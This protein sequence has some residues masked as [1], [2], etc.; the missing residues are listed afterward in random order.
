MKLSRRTRA[1]AAV[2]GAA[3]IAIIAAG[4]SPAS[5]SGSE[6]RPDRTDRRDVQRLRLHRRAPPGV[7][8]REPERHRSSTTRPRRRTTPARTTSRSSARKGLAD[9]E[10]VEVDW[11][12]EVMQ[13]SDLLA[14]VPD[15]RRGPLAR[16]EGSRSHRR[17]RPPHRLRHRHRPRRRIC[18][19]ADLF[20]AAGLPTDRDE[21]AALF[22]G[23]WDNYFDV[24]ATSTRPPPASRCSTPPARV[25]Q[26]MINQ[27]E[28]AYEEPDGTD[29][30]DRQPRGRGRYNASLERAR[31]ATSALPRPV[32]RRLERRRWP[33]AR[34]RPCSARAGCSASSRATRADVTGWDVAERLPERRR[35]LGRL[36]PDRPRQRRERRG[37]ARSSPTG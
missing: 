7:H 25:Y 28:F 18:Y 16:L 26:G 14:E 32:E 31:P 6:R 30:R 37:G 23:D 5:D 27:I 10:A 34:S 13:Y 36:V 15:R 8:G 12:T 11:L 19:R 21:V 2:A 20:A 3:S 17:R 33:T 29:H 9:V 35:Q 1:I 24:G 4:C 22:D